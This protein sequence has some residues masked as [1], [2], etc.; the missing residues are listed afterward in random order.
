MKMKQHLTVDYFK[1]LFFKASTSGLIILSV[2]FFM[3]EKEPNIVLSISLFALSMF[4][5]SFYRRIKPTPPL[6]TCLDKSGLIAGLYATITMSI[7]LGFILLASAFGIEKFV[8]EPT[9]VFGIAGAFFASGVFV[10][11]YNCKKNGVLDE[12]V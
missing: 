1:W 10:Y 9:I 6:A 3:I 4:T 5:F 11:I 12:N 8:Y 7:G 2:Y